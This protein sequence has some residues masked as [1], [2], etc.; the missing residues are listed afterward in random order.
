MIHMICIALHCVGVG[1]VEALVLGMLVL[2]LA[3]CE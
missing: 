3:D 2:A 1:D